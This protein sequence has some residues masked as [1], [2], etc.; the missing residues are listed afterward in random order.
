MNGRVKCSFA[1]YMDGMIKEKHNS[2]FSLKYMDEHLDEF[3]WFCRNN[4]P[5]KISLDKELV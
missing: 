1:Q 3:D 4:F 2:A 5:S